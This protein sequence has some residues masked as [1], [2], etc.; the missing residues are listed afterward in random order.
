M[1]ILLALVLT[2]CPS[3]PDPPTDNNGITPAPQEG[4]KDNGQDTAPPKGIGAA[5]NGQDKDTGY[6]DIQA[7]VNSTDMRVATQVAGF[8]YDLQMIHGYYDDSIKAMAAVDM[9]P[10]GSAWNSNIAK[11]AVSSPV[12]FNPFSNSSIAMGTVIHLPSGDIF[13]ERVLKQ[14]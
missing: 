1:I 13:P 10:G 11:Y 12:T 7:N 9:G 3:K 14:Q 2:A 6:A 5:G 4:Q 8:F